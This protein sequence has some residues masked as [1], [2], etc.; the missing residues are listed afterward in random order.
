MSENNID[1]D[2]IVGG[3]NDDELKDAQITALLERVDEL[4]KRVA[5]YEQ[6]GQEAR[7]ARRA[8]MK[9]T[10]REDAITAMVLLRDALR[11]IHPTTTV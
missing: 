9:A 6:R 11:A 8:V 1:F 4:T 2:A 3:I 7:H 10:T 5:V